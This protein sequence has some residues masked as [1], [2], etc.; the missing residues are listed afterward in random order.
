MVRMT[1]TSTELAEII[2]QFSPR[3]G[4][5]ECPVQGTYCIKVFDVNRRTKNHWPSALCIIVQ[6]TKEII[7]GR[8]TYRID[9]EPHYI[10]TAIDLPVTSRVAVATAQRPF[11]CLKIDIDPLVLSEVASQLGH[12]YAPL[13]TNAL[14]PV[15]IGKARQPLLDTSL[16]LA[17]LFQT[18]EDAAV[19]G[20]LVIREAF[21]HLLRGPDGPAIRQIARSGSKLH[22]I[23]QAIYSLK[24]EPGEDLDVDALAK[25]AGMSRSAFFKHFKQVTA[26]SPIQYQKRLRLLEARRLMANE[27]ETAEGSAYKVGYGSA[28]Q[29]SREYSRMF[30]SPPLRDASKIRTSGLS[31]AQA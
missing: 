3:D 8:E 30:G 15:F 16:R 13:S 7:L 20:P 11:L 27:G 24:S 23:S 12:V 22:K 9:G 31:L 14:G 17:R 28:S 25:T 19:L 26:M 29:F 2:G 5:N 1:N 10:A 21:Y 6:G 18:P 4:I